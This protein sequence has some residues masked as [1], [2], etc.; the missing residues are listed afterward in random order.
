[1][2]ALVLALLYVS[3]L[4]GTST[5][6]DNQIS[7]LNATLY[8][9][10][11]STQSFTS[12]CA[13]DAILSVESYNPMSVAIHITNVTLYGS[14]L[15]GNATTFVSLSNSCLSISESDPTLNATSS[16]TFIGYA[17]VGLQFAK[18]DWL[19]TAIRQWTGD[20]RDSVGPVRD[21]LMVI[22]SAVRPNGLVSKSLLKHNPKEFLI[23]T[24]G[25]YALFIVYR[26]EECRAFFRQIQCPL[27]QESFGGC[28]R[29]TWLPHQ[30]MSLNQTLSEYLF[31]RTLVFPLRASSFSLN[32]VRS[33]IVELLDVL[34]VLVRASDSCQSLL[35]RVSPTRFTQPDNC[36]L[37]NSESTR[38]ELQL[39][40]RQ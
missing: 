37:T 12:S 36:A 18:V 34:D 10:T 17:D 11:P 24:L 14:S 26:M 20:Q 4:P 16:N 29:R 31:S 22:L 38:P 27:S 32:L 13:G 25:Q 35:L 8:S 40:W 15:K 21:F 19:R 3:F 6:T 30:S 7:I 1:M 5:T 39:Q 28:F 33:W 2:V 23:L 9:G